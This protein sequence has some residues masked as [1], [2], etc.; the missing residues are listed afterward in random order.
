MVM[1]LGQALGVILGCDDEVYGC[2][3]LIVQQ[4][5]RNTPPLVEMDSSMFLVQL[6]GNT[7][8][9]CIACCQILL[10]GM[11]MV[12][13][14]NQTGLCFVSDNTTLIQPRSSSDVE[15][16]TS[17]VLNLTSMG[18]NLTSLALSLATHVGHV[19]TGSDCGQ[20]C[21]HDTGVTM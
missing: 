13:K 19:L 16:L 14:L 7:L 8:L 2:L 3:S 1:C 12:R 21:E 10:L 18:S 20:A 4:Q 11:A 15:H 17:M 6:V 5:S 9:S